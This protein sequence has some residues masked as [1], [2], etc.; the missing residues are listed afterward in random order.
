[1]HSTRL[2]IALAIAATVGGLGG[3]GEDESGRDEVRTVTT[4]LS[5]IA[6]GERKF[7]HALPSGNG[8]AC[9]TCH[10]EEEGFTLTPQRVQARFNALPR[11]ANG[12]IIYS[13]DPLFES[14]DAD[15]FD[16]DFTRLK[17]GLVRVTIPLPPNVSIDELPG[18]R[19]VDLFR[20][21]PSIWNVAITG[22]YLSDRRAAT[23]QEQA[24]GAATQHMRPQNMPSS[25]FFD[26]IVAYEKDQFSSEGVRFVA[27]EMAAGRTPARAEKFPLTAEEQ[28]GKEAFE[29]RCS[30][31]HGGHTLND[32]PVPTFV[33]R[34]LAV[35]VSRINRVNLPVYTFRFK[36]PNGAP[37]VVMPSPDPGHALISGDPNLAGEWEAFDVP[38]LYGISKTAPYFHDNSSQTLEDV[39][40]HYVDDFRF[41]KMIGIPDPAVQTEF[42]PW[43]LTSIVAYMK[44][45]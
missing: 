28:Q 36:M 18:A 41:A 38:T 3:C 9:A 43:E 7:D 12:N 22:P 45:L 39:M 6:D 2:G 25:A 8:R 20:A 24:R 10:V 30:Q 11:D 26:A 31:C 16:R 15:D 17:Q 29:H 37:D 33:S 32:G 1:M 21:V 19:S 23:L 5:A 4:P 27:S 44:T 42:E 13:A 40:Q 35:S 34:T 14:I